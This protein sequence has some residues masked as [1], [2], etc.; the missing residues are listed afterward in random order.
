MF[1]FVLKCLLVKVVDCGPLT[2]PDN[3]QANTS[4]G[5]TFGSTVT[6]TCN[7]GYTL[8]GS[9]SGTCEDNGM[10]TVL[11]SPICESEFIVMNTRHSKY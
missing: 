2:A 5:T 8:S 9:E 4:C 10:W 11:I 3:G 1:K 7:T 6:Y